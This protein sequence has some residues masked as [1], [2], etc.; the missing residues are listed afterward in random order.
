MKNI[1]SLVFVM[2]ALAVSGQ[3][4]TFDP[5]AKLVKKCNAFSRIEVTG[6]SNNREIFF[7]YQKAKMDT[8]VQYDSVLMVND[9]DMCTVID[10]VASLEMMR[11]SKGKIWL[12]DQDGDLLYPEPFDNIRITL[13]LLRPEEYFDDYCGFIVFGGYS[14]LDDLQMYRLV[15]ESDSFDDPHMPINYMVYNY[16]VNAPFFVQIK[17]KWGVYDLQKGMIVEPEYDKIEFGENG[18]ELYKG[19]V[20]AKIITL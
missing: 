9:P 4:T 16:D 17:G 20:I 13:P 5:P 7:Y 8:I 6:D 10:T 2:L 14:Y 12:L 18:L 15:K 1:L 19:D 11:L 3:E